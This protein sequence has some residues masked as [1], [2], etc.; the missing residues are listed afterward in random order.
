MALFVVAAHCTRQIG[1]GSDPNQGMAILN[2]S[3]FRPAV[4]FFFLVTSYFVYDRFLASGRKASVFFKSGLRYYG[5]Y[6]FWITLYLGIIIRESYVGKGLDSAYYVGWFFQEFFLNSPISV[7]WFLRASAYGLILLGV[8]FLWKKMKPLYLLPLAL[9][10]YTIGTFG[11]SY[12]GFVSGGIKEAYVSYFK[13]FYY[14]RNMMFDAFPT[15]VIGCLIR[16]YKD[17]IPSTKTASIVIWSVAAIGLGFVFLESWLLYRYSTPK[18]YNFMFSFLLFVPAL[19]LGLLRINKP[20]HWRAAPYLGD[21]SSLVYFVHIAFRD[22]YNDI[23]L[24]TAYEKN[25]YLRFALVSLFALFA[26]C[27]IVASTHPSKIRR[28]IY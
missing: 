23:F 9:V 28:W 13:I 8:L 12:Y 3:L 1:W 16:E 11:D 27:A 22:L 14:S 26:A 18:D 7:F 15:F 24:G 10:L 17:K 5:I 21:V 6:V 2:S 4:T 20:M 25:W 19:F